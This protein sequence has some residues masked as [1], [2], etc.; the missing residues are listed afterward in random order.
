[1]SFAESIERLITEALYLDPNNVQDNWH[2]LQGLL[3][4]EQNMGFPNLDIRKPEVQSAIRTLFG[5]LN[6]TGCT[7]KQVAESMSP[8]TWGAFR[9]ALLVIYQ[10]SKGRRA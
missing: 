5:C 4:D 2:K 6:P 1:M 9:K 7:H 3:H 10:L 8:E